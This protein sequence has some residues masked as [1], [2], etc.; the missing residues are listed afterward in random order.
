MFGDE[1]EAGKEGVADVSTSCGG[2]VASNGGNCHPFGWALRAGVAD[3]C[4]P[5]VSLLVHAAV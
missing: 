5:N 4:F 2:G 3:A 1:R